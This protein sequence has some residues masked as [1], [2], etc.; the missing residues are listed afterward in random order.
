MELF[1]REFDPREAVA[2]AVRFAPEVF[3]ERIKRFV[4]GA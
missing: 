1:L 4:A 2:Q 3:D